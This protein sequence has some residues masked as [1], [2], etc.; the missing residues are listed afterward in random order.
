MVTEWTPDQVIFGIRHKRLFGFLGRAGDILDAISALNGTVPFRHDFFAGV[1]WPN[2]VT[3]R[4]QDRDG[5][6]LVDANIDGVVVTATLGKGDLTREK[7]KVMFSRIA[8]VVLPISGGD[9]T[10][11]RIGI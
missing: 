6:F 10:V 8:R 9:T 2:R 1:N 7:V 3:A 11:N 4:A 5:K